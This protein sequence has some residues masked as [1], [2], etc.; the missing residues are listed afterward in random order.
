MYNPAALSDTHP[1][2]N[3]MMCEQ[4]LS[5]FFTKTFQWSAV[6]VMMIPVSFFAIKIRKR[7][8]DLV[9]TNVLALNRQNWYIKYIQHR[10]I[11]QFFSESYC[12]C[13]LNY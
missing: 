9:R 2:A 10:N 4:I 1:E 8:V 13:M 12:N 7:L 3:L 11:A 6:G 5:I